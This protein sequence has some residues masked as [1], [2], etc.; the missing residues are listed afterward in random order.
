MRNRK[1]ASRA[2]WILTQLIACVTLAVV[3]AAAQT[4]AGYWPFDDGSGTRAADSSGNG[5]TATLVNG[6][7]WTTGRV[8]GAVSANA[9][10]SQSVSVPAIDL[11]GTQS[12]TVAAWSKRTY[13]VT[14][15]HALF[16]ATPD[17]TASTS[18]FAL[19]P[20]DATCQGVQAALIGNV[21]ETANC[22]AQPS[23]GVWHHLAVVYDKTQT[24]GNQVAFYVDGVLQSPIRSLYAST[25]TNAFGANPIYLFSQGGATLFDTGKLDD[26][27]IYA[28]A[29]TS[30]QIQQIYTFGKNQIAEDFAVSVDG[31][32]LM[33]TPSFTTSVSNELLV[34]FVAYDGPASPTQTA[35]VTG[36]GLSWTLRKR[37]N[38]QYGTSEIWA[39]TA[40][41]AT[42]TATVSSQP[43]TGGSYH[44]SLTV[45]GFTNAS[46][47]GIV[48]QAGAVSGAPDIKLSAITAGNWIFAVGND[49][50]NPVSRTPVSG[51]ILVHQRVDTQIGDTYWLQ[52]T[53]APST[54]T[55][56]V[57]IHDSA[58]TADRW[59]Y[60]A[61]EIVSSTNSTVGTLTA[62]PTSLAFGNVNVNSSASQTVTISNTGSA[63]V[64]VSAVS[65]TGNGF[66]LAAVT[67]PFTLIAG[68]TKQLTATFSPTIAGS[69]S[70][71]ITVT[72]N[73]SDPSLGIPLSGTGVAVIGTLTAS[74]TSVNFGNVNVNTSASQTVTI[75]NS[76]NGSVIVSAVSI[77]GNGFTLAAVTTPFTLTAGA[78]K[79]LTATFSPTIA[80]LASGSITVTSN[81][82]NPNLSVPLTGTGVAVIGTLTASPTSVNFGNVNVNSSASQTVTITNSGS[83]LVTVSAVSIT[84]SE[85]TLAAVTTP[86][87]LAAGATK[88]LTATF[89]PTVP[90]TT[91]GSIT[92]TSNASNPSLS[93]PLSGTGVS[94]APHDVALSW[95][96]S[97]SPVVGYN[98]YRSTSTSG[99]FSLVNTGVV[100]SFSYDDTTVLSGI[101]YYYYATAV[102][103]QGNESVPSA[104][105]SATVP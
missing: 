93:I 21:G 73:A 14:G 75:T 70:G 72:S 103:A 11:S 51:Q 45:I 63:S 71:S 55:G 99:P 95:T 53:G 6:V 57:D 39:A 59:N 5:H 83:G 16:E 3:S 65:I 44:G 31:A 48:G 29:L 43:G 90:G 98:V 42:L 66:T 52:S 77:T 25:N 26:F 47:T 82:S 19:F 40:P 74:P 23:S 96:A 56:A 34:A 35:T 104:Q 9:S 50:D 41:S 58:P 85:L 94:T 32:G 86:F 15:G 62:S 24:A 102:D 105:A 10:L 67:T 17:F 92:V 87:T 4:A 91:S 13:S 54:V 61:V 64:T 101:T 49:W 8:G 28:S 97:T 81:A 46:S 89:S 60:A 12:V 79:Q 84:G 20:D 33:T 38:S 2:I 76:G 69:A 18:G 88:P 7:A 30:A 37:S 1:S 22:Y 68:A 27:R 100:S 80:G 78:K 36:G